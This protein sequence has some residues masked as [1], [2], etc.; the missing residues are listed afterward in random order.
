MKAGGIC[1]KLL[2]MNATAPQPSSPS[3]SEPVFKL[4]EDLRLVPGPSLSDGSPSWTLH[5]PARNRFF[6]IGWPEFEILSRWHLQDPEAIAEAVCQETPLSIDSEEVSELGRFFALNCLCE[7]SH[8]RVLA[9]LHRQAMRK[10]PHFL[11]WLLH[12]YL[13][14]RIPLVRPDRFLDATLPLVRF[15]MRPLFRY[16]LIAAMVLGFY[17]ILRQWEPFVHTFLEFFTLQG[18]LYYALALIVA[19][20]IHELGHAYSTKHHGLKVPTMGIAFLVLWPML[21]TDNSE[22]WKL[23]DKKARM[24]IVVAGTVA[25]LVLAVLSTLMWSFLPEGPAKSACFILATVTWISSLMINLSPFLRF[26]GYYLLSD[27]LEVPNLHDRAAAL[28]RWYLR[29]LLFGWDRQPPEDFPKKKR[30]FLILFAYCTW[31]YRLL[32]FTAIALMVYHL[33]FKTLGL[34]LFSVEIGWFIIRPV[35]REFSAWWEE[36]GA[37]VLNRNIA[38]TFFVL[39]AVIGFFAWPRSARIHAPGLLKPKEYVRVY[40]PFAARIQ[41]VHVESGQTV[42][43]GDLLFSLKSPW[44]EYKKQQARTRVQVL[45]KQLQRQYGDESL[46]EGTK[47]LQRQLAG[48]MTALAGYRAQEKRSRIRSP[49]PGKVRDLAQGLEPGRWVN[50]KELLA[51]VVNPEPCLVEAYLEE[52]EIDRVETGKIALFYRENRDSSPIY[53]QL[54]QIDPASSHQLKAPY[55]ASVYGGEIPARLQDGELVSHKSLYRVV[56]D[57]PDL[58]TPPAQIIRGKA[59][60]QGKPVIPL[61]QAWQRVLSVFIRESGF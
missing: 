5:D 25:E 46:L 26:D 19:K 32:L 44:L 2:F 29:K 56:L 38:I 11:T 40:P 6:R 13:F 49:I 61:Y 42:A 58:P 7:P 12:H 4:R 48:A 17:L 33:F 36:R 14:I 15:L 35:S 50:K 37:F 54:S 24:G 60:I 23:T 31:I 1:C 53:C 27:F 9:H 52:T 3:Q 34:F 45:E 8:P 10:K 51:L 41:T 18:F 55:L 16:L 20:I 59:V 57:I 39:I 28:G 30:R 21:Y 22:A 43:P 47:V